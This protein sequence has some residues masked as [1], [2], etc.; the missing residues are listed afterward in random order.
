MMYIHDAN[1]GRLGPILRI[2]NPEFSGAVMVL[3][4]Q[5]RFEVCDVDVVAVINKNL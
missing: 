2:S 1:E 4:P 3:I 5:F